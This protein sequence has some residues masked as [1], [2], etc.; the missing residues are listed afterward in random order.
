VSSRLR[1]EW[2]RHDTLETMARHFS[3]IRDFHFADLLTLANGACGTAAILLAMD[4]MREG[5]S[6]KLYAGGASVVLALVFDVADG[7]VA[8][9]RHRA[10]A[11]GRELDSLADVISFGVAPAALGFAAGL[12]GLLDILALLYFVCCGISRLARYNITAEAMSAESGKVTHFE[13]TPIPSS[14]LLVVLLLA[15]TWAGLSGPELPG[16]IVSVSGYDLHLLSLLYVLSG[17][18][19][20]SKT[21]HIPKP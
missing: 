12:T 16:G 10:S 21:L 6:A 2:G 8:R 17:S 19:M 15:L 4:Y 18:L 3:M 5:S 11:M 20:I 14:V 9:W 13:G 1:D 7:R